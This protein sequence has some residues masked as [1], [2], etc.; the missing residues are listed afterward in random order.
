M[1]RT[2]AGKISPPL[3]E[4][5]KAKQTSPLPAGLWRGKRPPASRS[6]LMTDSHGRCSVGSKNGCAQHSAGRNGRSATPNE[7]PASGHCCFGWQPADVILSPRILPHRG[8]RGLSR[9]VLAFAL[10]TLFKNG[11]GSGNDL[12]V[13]TVATRVEVAHTL[14]QQLKAGLILVRDLP[15]LS[16]RG[17]GSLRH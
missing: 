17:G 1:A 9:L 13:V 12:G 16:P 11:L 8:T 14:V 4:L 3:G 6:R 7:R 5:Q 2:R 10:A 15:T